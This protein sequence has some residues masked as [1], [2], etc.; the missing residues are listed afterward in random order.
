MLSPKKRMRLALRIGEADTWE[1]SD[2]RKKTNNFDVTG[3][4]NISKI[5]Y[6]ITF[7]YER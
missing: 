1:T 3:K 6:H 4:E 7:F 2:S 5:R